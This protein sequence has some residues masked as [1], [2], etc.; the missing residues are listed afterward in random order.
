MD[1]TWRTRRAVEADLPGIRELIDLFA[2]RHPAAHAPRP[3]EVLARA[4]FGPGAVTRLLV[5]E[6]GERL[7]GLAGWR[8]IFDLFW[9][10]HGGEA[11]GLFVRAEERGR[12]VAVGLVAAVCADIRAHGGVFLRAT[13]NEAL[14]PFYERVAVGVHLKECHLSQAA[15]QRVADLAGKPARALVELPDPSLN[16]VPVAR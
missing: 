7:I 9:A 12:A 6:Q 13:Y 3:P 16:Y 14:A 5:A 10:I 1:G 4:F 8:P 11:E 2:A 15:F